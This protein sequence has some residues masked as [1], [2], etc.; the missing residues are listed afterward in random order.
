M[1]WRREGALP[2]DLIIREINVIIVLVMIIVLILWLYICFYL[3][4]IIA[5]TQGRI[6]TLELLPCVNNTIMMS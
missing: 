5:L 6:S 2:D 3:I 1:Y 4:I